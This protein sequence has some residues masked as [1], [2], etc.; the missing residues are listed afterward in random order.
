MT[1]E[2]V[3]P[4]VEYSSTYDSGAIDFRSGLN[5]LRE[6]LVDLREGAAR[7]EAETLTS[8]IRYADALCAVN[9]WAAAT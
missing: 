4:V 7:S 6:R 9:R 8:Y 5:A 2:S 1:A 3:I